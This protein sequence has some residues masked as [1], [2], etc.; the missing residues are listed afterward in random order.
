MYLYCRPQQDQIIVLHVVN[1]ISQSPSS[2]GR[3]LFISV[4]HSQK[5][6]LMKKESIWFVYGKTDTTRNGNKLGPL[7]TTS[8]V[9]VFFSIHIFYLYS[10]SPL[11]S[12]PIF[13]LPTLFSCFPRHI[14]PSYKYHS[15]FQCPKGFLQG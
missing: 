15:I 14:L 1:V 7:F 2:P 5:V 8:V 4:P 6:E 11:G 13:S 12:S 3:W 10:A 9:C